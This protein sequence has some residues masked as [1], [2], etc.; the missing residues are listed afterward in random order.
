MINK[1][2]RLSH[3]TSGHGK[4]VYEA[5]QHNKASNDWYLAGDSSLNKKYI[6]SSIELHNLKIKN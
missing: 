3:Y 4:R 1:T 2:Q 5:E 6:T